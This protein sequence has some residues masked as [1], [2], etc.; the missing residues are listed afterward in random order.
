MKTARA[1]VEKA[2]ARA[3]WERVVAATARGDR[4]AAEPDL[5]RT[6]R[7]L[8]AVT[9]VGFQQAEALAHGED[10]TRLGLAGDTRLG[11]EAIQGKTIDFLGIAFLDQARAASGCVGRVI[12]RHGEPLV[13][14]GKKK[15]LFR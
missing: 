10:P 15:L 9:G 14:H 11:A 1:R 2:E 12:Y 6:I 7:R 13:L 8:Q 5:Q 3:Q 4:L